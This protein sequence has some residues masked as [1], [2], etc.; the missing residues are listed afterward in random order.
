MLGGS[1][2]WGFGARDDYTI[3]SLL[4]RRLFERK[5]NVRIKNLSEIG[6]VSTQEVVALLRELQSGYRPDVL[7]F[8]DGVNDTTS[9]VLEGAAGLSTN[10]VNRRNEFNL[11]QS[12]SRLARGLT[13]ALLKSSGALRIVQAVRS[14]L[15]PDAQR[16]GASLSEQARIQ[17]AGEVVRRY[18]ANVAIVEKLGRECRFAPLFYWQPIVFTKRSMVPFEREEAGR[19][20]ELEP[21]FRHIET[22]IRASKALS[23][24]RAFRDLSDSLAGSNQLVF[25]DYCHTTE[26]ANTVIAELMADDVMAAIT[27]VTSVGPG[28]NDRGRP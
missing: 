18:E 11:L 16:T 15:L 7:V 9:A 14:R 8:Y 3:P 25:I 2:L 13:S 17:L 23:A 24:D 20:A 12:P 19:Y 22:A 28:S 5:R 4:T 1:S 27:P 10:E 6:Y 21:M 26:A